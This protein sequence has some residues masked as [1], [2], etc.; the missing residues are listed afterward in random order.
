MYG[1]ESWPLSK[2]DESLL[3]IFER[4]ILR[5]ID[6]PINEGGMWRIRYNNELHKLYNEPDT[7]R[8]IKMGRL[9][10]LGHLFRLQELDP[11]RKLTL[12]KPEGTGRVGKPRARW[13]ESVETDLKKMDVKNWRRKA[14]DREQWRT[15]LKEAKVHQGL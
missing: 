12:H 4:R 14:Q 1:S 2:K 7:V 10:W 8:V 5:R 3:Q 9:R 15:I 13:L 11:C 6:G